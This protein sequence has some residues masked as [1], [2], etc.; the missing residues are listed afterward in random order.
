MEHLQEAQKSLNELTLTTIK[1]NN[2][3]A[4]IYTK[5]TTVKEFGEGLADIAKLFDT[6]IRCISNASQHIVDDGP[7][8]VVK[9]IM[10]GHIE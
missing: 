4:S 3:L 5:G 9:L 10:E 1:I 8:Q 7:T 6:A 2:I